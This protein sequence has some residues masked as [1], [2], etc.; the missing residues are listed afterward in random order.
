MIDPIKDTRV[1]YGNRMW[2]GWVAEA[3][4]QEVSGV[5][6]LGR[7][8][9]DT[10]SILEWALWLPAEGVGSWGKC[11]VDS[12]GKACLPFLIAD[13]YN[14]QTIL[15]EAGVW[16]LNPCCQQLK[17]AQTNLRVIWHFRPTVLVVF[18]QLDTNLYIS[19]KRNFNWENASY[20][21]ACRHSEFSPYVIIVGGPK[22]TK[23]AISRQVALSCLRKQAEQVMRSK[24]VSS[25][26]PLL[27]PQ[28]LPPGF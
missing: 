9:G 3:G 10:L 17:W 15:C 24:Q 4:W 26:P 5:W 20:Q 19:A 2:P 22:P 28:I 7:V 23:G 12:T 6:E 16:T 11:N 1:G 8:L 18:C 25:T 27:L 14:S 21:I 13:V